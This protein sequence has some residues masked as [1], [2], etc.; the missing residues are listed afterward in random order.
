MRPQ[1]LALLISIS[2]SSVHAA[3]A[4]WT[5]RSQ[6][7]KMVNGA[8]ALF[9]VK[10]PQS[11]ESLT[12]NWLGHE[13]TFSFDKVGKTWFALAGVSIETAPGTYALE[14][15]GETPA[16]KT[17]SQKIS[18]TRN[19]TV[20]RGKY[21]K[22]K[23]KLNV[24]SKFTEPSPEQHKQIEE[25]QQVKKDYLSRVTAEREWSGSFTAPRRSAD[26]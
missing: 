2:L 21:P 19:F 5:V 25:S 22:I 14:L 6:P 24:E 15:T 9:Q 23:V 12:A 13:V 1:L 20:T 7:A 4:N 3:A 11:L 16:G 17:P 18:F 26:L 8:P 10:P